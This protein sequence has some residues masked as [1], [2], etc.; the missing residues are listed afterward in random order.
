M[1]VLFVRG[2]CLTAVEGVLYILE[3][4]NYDLNIDFKRGGAASVGVALVY[5]S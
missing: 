2:V 3:S 4:G 1:Y 5:S